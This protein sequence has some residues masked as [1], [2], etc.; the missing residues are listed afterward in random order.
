M[1]ADHYEGHDAEKTLLLVEDE[2]IIAMCGGADAVKVSATAS[3]TALSG[4]ERVEL[5]HGKT[6]TSALF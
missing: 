6:S 4:E 2:A 1:N 5:S 3:F